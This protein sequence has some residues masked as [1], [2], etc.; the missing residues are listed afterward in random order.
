[1]TGIQVHPPVDVSLI[2]TRP[3][4]SCE[5]RT[6]RRIYT[7][8]AGNYSRR[9]PARP[10]AAFP[11]RATCRS[12]LNGCVRTA[13]EQGGQLWQENQ[14]TPKGRKS[15]HEDAGESTG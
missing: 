11:S 4:V 10:F 1:M 3:P 8:A 9:A 2:T 12:D 14:S 15:D 7:V 6:L 13:G 5:N